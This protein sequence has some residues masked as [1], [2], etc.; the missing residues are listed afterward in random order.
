MKHRGLLSI[1]D[2]VPQMLS[3]TCPSTG[4]YFVTNYLGLYS[5]KVIS[6][7]IYMSECP[8]DKVEDN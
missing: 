2:N 3:K 1:V 8:L 6:T 5:V 4:V 7:E